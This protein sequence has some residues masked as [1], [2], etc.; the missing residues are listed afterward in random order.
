M[1]GS[2]EPDFTCSTCFA[3]LLCSAPL[4]SYYLSRFFT[5]PL[6]LYSV[7]AVLLIPTP[8]RAVDACVWARTNQA[9]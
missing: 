8:F 7:E 4:F 6:E 5:E 2:G 1:L 9:Q 3:S